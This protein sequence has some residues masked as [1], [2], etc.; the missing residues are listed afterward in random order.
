V[1]TESFAARR[2]GHALALLSFTAFVSSIAWPLTGRSEPSV[3]AAAAPAGASTSAEPQ[4]IIPT[5]WQPAHG[6]EC[7][8]S[9][10]RKGFCQGP[11]RV[12]VPHGAEAELAHRLGLGTLEAAGDLMFETPK[13]EWIDAAGPAHEETLLFPVE[14]GEVWRGMQRPHRTKSGMHGRHKGVDIGAPEGSL[15]RAVKSGLVGYS[16]NGV[17]GYGNLLAVVHP[18]GSVAAYGHC[19]AI[20]V[21]AGQHVARGQVVGEVGHTGVA[22]GSHLHFEYREAGKLRDPLVRFA[23]R[24]DK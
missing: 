12:P 18:D 21:F 24:P 9:G 14:A 8:R 2:A 6:S 1:Q 10:R 3:L 23:D 4:V 15:I 17:H 5:Q 22:R 13:Q 11:R 16:D 19:R 7:A 20:Y